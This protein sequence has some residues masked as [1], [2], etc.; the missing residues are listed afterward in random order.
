MNFPA[1]PATNSDGSMTWRISWHFWLPCA[2]ARLLLAAFLVALL[3]CGDNPPV[4][5][6]TAPP[7]LNESQLTIGPGDKLELVIYF[8]QNESKATY[9]LDST[10]E[11]AVRYIG[12]VTA[13][14]KTAAQLKD[15]I[16]RALADGYLKDPIVSIT[17]AEINSRKLSVLG[18]VGRTGNIKYVPGMT[19]TDAIAQSGGFTPMARKNLVRVTRMVDG[20]SVTWELPAEMIGKGDRPTFWVM[21][22]D[23]VFVPERVF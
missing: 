9:T 10:G 18:Q 17:V 21:P 8:G 15:E 23:I 3:A 11:I 4:V 19:I 16:Q 6:P 7:S 12:T 20:K 1:R 5:Y 22:G 14:G 13:T 2:P